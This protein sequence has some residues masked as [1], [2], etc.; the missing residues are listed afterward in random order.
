[1]NNVD[2]KKLLIISF[3]SIF[4]FSS[5][6]GGFLAGYKIAKNSEEKQE[7]SLPAVT[8]KSINSST[9]E[10]VKNNIIADVAESAM[11]WVVN[12]RTEIEQKYNADLFFPFSPFFDFE[13]KENPQMK[14]KVTG[15]SGIIIKKDGYILTNG[16][17]VRD[18]DNIEVRL[19]NGKSYK[20]KKIGIDEM[21]DIAILKIQPESNNLPV[22]KLGNSIKL[23]I[24]E[25]VIAVGSPLGYEQTVTQ[26]IVSAIN[27]HVRDIPASVDFI[28]TDAAI[29]PGNS[30][31]PLI[32]L[33]GEVIGINTAIRADAQNIGFA[34]P[35]NTAK[36]IAEQLIAQGYVSR[37]W[38]GVEMRE[39]Y[40][41]YG[42]LKGVV[43]YRIWPD[44]PAKKSGLKEEDI[45]IK[46]DGK[47]VEDAR[48]VQE[49]VKN[50]KVGDVIT[51]EILRDDSI[52]KIKVK[53][54]KLP[55]LEQ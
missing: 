37:P 38:I 52:K 19:T 27:R 41:T 4:L 54:E 13:N 45:I 23:R 35:V 3:S 29:N 2:L 26:G 40:P 16:H 8:G 12:I 43:I 14:V 51:F 18:T 22:A 6:L 15:G 9:P 25:W 55:K 34:I 50:H 42:N 46:V 20:A 10:L 17:V 47:K 31:G 24:G 32:N 33:A 39:L 48:D 30:G 11:P 7:L 53:T 5:T 44:S 49:K 1:M 21:T 36:N 28:Q